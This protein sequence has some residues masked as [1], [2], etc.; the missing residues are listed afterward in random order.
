MILFFRLIAAVALMCV[1]M[2][3]QAG[4][5]PIAWSQSGSLPAT[6]ELNHSYAINFT[7]TNQLPFTMP[8]PLYISNN[9]NPLTETT[10]VDNCSGR[11]LTPNQSCTVGLVLIPKS[12][13]VKHLSVYMEYGSNKVKI[14]R[15]PLTTTVPAGASSSLLGVASVPLPTSILSNSTYSITFKFTNNSSN[16]LTGLVVTPNANNSPG[17]TQTSTTC[18]GQLAASGGVCYVNG[19]FTTAATSGPVTVGVTLATNTLSASAVTSSIISSTA[20]ASRTITFINNC[21]DTVY[22]GFVGGAVNTNPCTS[23]AQCGQG[24][25]CDP[26]ANSGA[27]ECFYVNPTPTSG[28]YALTGSGGTA[29]VPITDYNLQYVW[30][31]NIAARTGPTCGTGACD[32]ADCGS[33]TGNEACPTGQGFSQPATLAEFTMQRGTIDSYDISVINGINRGVQITPT[34]TGTFT[35]NGI[36]AYNCQSPGNP[37]A[38]PALGLGACD[39]VSGFTPP[40]YPTAT[41]PSS[42]IYVKPPTSSPTACTDNTP[43]VTPPYS[44]CGLN[45]NSSNNTLSKVCGEFLG[46]VTANQVCSFAN[47]NQN[48]PNAGNNPGDAYFDCDSSLGSP[49]ATYTYWAMLACKAQANGDLGTCYNTAANPPASTPNC[50]GCINWQNVPGV[51]VPSSTTTCVNTNTLWTSV[52]SGVLPGITWLKEGCPTAYSYPFDDKSSGFG[53]MDINASNTTNTVNYTITFCPT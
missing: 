19:T 31:G 28:S 43:C 42:Y 36:P 18:S 39:W 7:L 49:M 12:S 24:S 9:S 44:T 34:T 47:T 11:R 30:S 41:S 17:F 13:G 23:D 37:N 4:K 29:T 2:A 16:I 15:T 26:A 1:M 35:P 14:P 53:C 8:T 51:T 20:A 50:C 46:Y 52:S 22:F 10:L 40:A 25:L 45:F 6:A 48:V 33:A 21:S 5:D 3:A 32:T 27:G 38:V